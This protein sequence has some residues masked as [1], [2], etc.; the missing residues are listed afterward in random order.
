MTTKAQQTAKQ[1]AADQ[2]RKWLKPGDTVY[3]ILRH[4]SRSGMQREI[5]LYVKTPDGMQWLDGY[6]RHVLGLRVGKRE[7]LVIGGCGMDMGFELVY[8][9][10]YALFGR[11]WTCTGKGCPSNGHSNGDQD[12]TPHAHSDGGYALSQRWL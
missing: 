2:L 1:E 5:S 6:A 3:T 10:G 11:E 8:Q 4:V 7:G 9:L 12:Y